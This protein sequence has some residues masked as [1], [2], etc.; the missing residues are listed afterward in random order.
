MPIVKCNEWDDFLRSIGLEGLDDKEKNEIISR[1]QNIIQ[2]SIELKKLSISFAPEMLDN[3][4]NSYLELKKQGV[5]PIIS[6]SKRVLAGKTFEQYI[7]TR[8]QQLKC[9]ELDLNNAKI[10]YFNTKKS[11]DLFD[12]WISYK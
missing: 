6:N 12:F 9:A 2:N 11:K 5:N 10:I 3:L 7:E 4:E 8:R 1:Y